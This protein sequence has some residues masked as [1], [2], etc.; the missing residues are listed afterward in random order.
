M[1]WAHIWLVNL[2]YSYFIFFRE[3]LVQLG[4]YNLSGLN[5]TWTERNITKISVHPDFNIT[6]EAAYYDVAIITLGEAVEFNDDIRPI[7]LPGGPMNKADH[8]TGLAVSI[9]GWGLTDNDPS[10]KSDI[11]KTANLRIYNQRY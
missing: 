4:A 11:L 3:H 2:P 7:C 10:A 8:L 6:S 5:E 1:I 9:S